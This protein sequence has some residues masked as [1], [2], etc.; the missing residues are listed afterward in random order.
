VAIYYPL[1]SKLSSW[2]LSAICPLKRA[3]FYAKLIIQQF[4]SIHINTQLKQALQS[5]ALIPHLNI[6]KINLVNANSQTLLFKEVNTLPCGPHG[7]WSVGQ[8]LF[9]LNTQK[10]QTNDEEWRMPA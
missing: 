3:S 9:N 4:S 6:S 7:Y 10:T 5:F 2:S 8:L 1:Q